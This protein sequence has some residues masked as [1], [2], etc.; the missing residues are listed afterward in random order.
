[1]KT[2]NVG[3]SLEFCCEREQRN[4]AISGRG[5]EARTLF[6]T[7]S[8]IVFWLIDRNDPAKTEIL[9]TLKK[10]GISEGTTWVGKWGYR[11]LPVPSIMTV[12]LHWK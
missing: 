11:E 6:K 12:S 1:M 10:T 7:W 5:Y 8:N 2:V 9:M 3:S 4:G